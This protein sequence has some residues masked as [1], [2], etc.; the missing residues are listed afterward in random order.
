M[1]LRT[2]QPICTLSSR[3]HLFVETVSICAT[4]VH[5]HRYKL[6]RVT[7]YICV[8]GLVRH[9]SLSP[10]V[11]MISHPS[12]DQW[13]RSHCIAVTV[14]LCTLYIYLCNMHLI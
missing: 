7:L 13:L 11:M 10:H 2:D 3:K 6:T 1:S 8:S 14:I 4:A 12:D 5:Q 9:M